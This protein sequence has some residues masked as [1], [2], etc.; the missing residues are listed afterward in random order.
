MARG[1]VQRA[2][3]PTLPPCA[4]TGARTHAHRGTHLC[5]H[6]ERCAQRRGIQVSQLEAWHGPGGAT[7]GSVRTGRGRPQTAAEAAWR[8]P[9]HDALQSARGR[10]ACAA[11]WARCSR[12]ALLLLPYTCPPTC[13]IEDSHHLAVAAVPVP[14][15]AAGGLQA[16]GDEALRG[17]RAAP[18]VV[19]ASLD[20]QQR[21]ARR[22]LGRRL[23][24]DLAPRQLS[25]HL[26]LQAGAGEC[27]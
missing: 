11:R 8:P 3:R 21:A 7:A 9:P 17:E 1:H 24:L 5:K 15:V 23:Q 18:R 14:A 6:G 19:Q 12:V 27:R 25:G 16:V 20:D 4:R 22:P 26:I 2:R 13:Q 10:A